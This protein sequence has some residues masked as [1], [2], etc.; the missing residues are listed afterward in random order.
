[1]RY[2]GPISGLGGGFRAVH[3]S[4]GGVTTIIDSLN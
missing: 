3:S 2:R 4:I 1:M